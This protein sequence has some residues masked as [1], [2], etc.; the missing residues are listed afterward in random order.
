[1]LPNSQT[2]E[3]EASSISCLP[4]AQLPPTIPHRRSH[5]S[6]L[7]VSSMSNRF[8]QSSQDLT[9]LNESYFCDTPM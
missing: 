8:Q 2:N 7:S 1:M 9:E 5:G 6:S 4:G 3:I